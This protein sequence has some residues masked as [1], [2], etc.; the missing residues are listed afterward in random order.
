KKTYIR[1]LYNEKF[2][3]KNVNRL[4]LEPQYLL[5]LKIK[6]NNKMVIKNYTKYRKKRIS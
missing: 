6:N 2:R 1:G 3:N 5:K 4:L